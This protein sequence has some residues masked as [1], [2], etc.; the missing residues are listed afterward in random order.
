M[1]LGSPA[2]VMLGIGV[3]TINDAGPDF[4]GNHLIIHNDFLWLLVEGGPITLV[5]VTVI[6]AASLRNCF[7][8]ARARGADSPIAIGVG[9]ALIGTLAWTVG[10]EGLWHRHV[11]LLLALS[12]ACYA[13]SA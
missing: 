4:L 8:A 2:S 6:F 1:Y 12:E 3:G 13:L 9:C 10:T 5:L 7:V 11:W